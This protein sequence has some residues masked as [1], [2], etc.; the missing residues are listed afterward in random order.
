MSPIF[1]YLQYAV[2]T[3][4]MPSQAALDYADTIPNNHSPYPMISSEDSVLFLSALEGII[5]EGWAVFGNVS[6]VQNYRVSWNEG[7][8]WLDVLDQISDESGIVIRINWA[9]KNIYII[10]AVEQKTSRI[11]L[12]KIDV[13]AAK[14][15]QQKELSKRLS[16]VV[17]ENE[18]LREGLSRFSK[19]QDFDRVVMDIHT[20]SA[21]EMTAN[22][23]AVIVEEVLSDIDLASLY[24]NMPPTGIYLHSL[25]NGDVRSLVVT[26][27][28][29]REDQ[30]LIV[31]DVESGS[32]L[33]NIHRLSAHYDWKVASEGW[34]LPVDYQIKYGYPLLVNDFFGGLSKLLKRYPVQ[35]QLMQHTQEVAFV[36]R[37]LTANKPS[38]Y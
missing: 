20:L 21:N 1:K 31:F 2:L 3:L 24:N 32:L 33:A 29:F 27:R 16:F 25:E 10:D 17:F 19:T 18:A 37:P 34:Q 8:S 11:D 13:E 30:S 35:A 7:D 26:D 6:I 23:S 28:L 22:K 12:A 4:A 36:S 14:L 15:T 9:D 38:D 5:P